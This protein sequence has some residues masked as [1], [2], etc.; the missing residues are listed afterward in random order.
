LTVISEE[1]VDAALCDNF[2]HRKSEE[3]HAS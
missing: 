1:V 2:Q 3:D